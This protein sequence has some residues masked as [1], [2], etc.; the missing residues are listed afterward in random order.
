MTPR[1]ARCDWAGD[2]P[3]AHVAASG[4]PLCVVCARSLR[5]DESQTCARCVGVVRSDLATIAET[6]VLLPAELV[7]HGD[8]PIP[9]GDA[10]VQ[11][12][13]G[14]PSSDHD[15]LASDPESVVTTLA[16]WEDDWRVTFGFAAAGPATVTDAVGFLSRQ[17][18]RA[19]SS[20]P[21][22]DEFAR[23]VRRLVVRL[24]VT[25]A[26]G[27]WPLRAPV[28]CFDCGEER[29]E[30]PYGASGLADDWTCRCCGRRYRQEEYYLALRALLEEAV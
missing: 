2:D 16:A 6:Y 25:T 18:G 12:A 23:D 14:S 27:D 4:H 28:R 5:L 7:H 13:P 20:H 9:G 10:L 11:L 26:T 24:Q 3:A 8:E 21:A 17:V 15:A 30:R 1:C 19:A 22:F 29:L